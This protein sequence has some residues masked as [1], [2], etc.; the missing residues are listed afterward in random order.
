MA[1]GTVDVKRHDQAWIVSLGG[2]H[3]L[4][5]QPMLTDQLRRLART[6]D[7]GAEERHHRESGCQPRRSRPG[8]SDGC[9]SRDG[10]PVGHGEVSTGGPRWQGKHREPGLMSLCPGTCWSPRRAVR[11]RS[12]PWGHTR[13]KPGPGTR[14]TP[15][16]LCTTA[17]RM[18]G[19]QGR[20]SASSAETMPRHFGQASGRTSWIRVAAAW[21]TR[22]AGGPPLS[23]V[24]CLVGMGAGRP[25]ASCPSS[26]EARPP[27]LT[28]RCL[29][30]RS[31]MA[32][33]APDAELDVAAPWYLLVTSESG[34]SP[35]ATMGPY[36]SH[37][38]ARRAADA[39]RVMYYRIASGRSARST[40]RVTR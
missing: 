26:G 2:E 14:R 17:S 39:A 11:V 34:K 22:S 13:P 40:V 12:R 8:D 37:A 9:P 3:D 30:R 15:R 20:R 35:F 38:E 32:R 21:E 24:P 31:T 10:G 18:P 19:A 36:T 29:H 6:G 5:T 28:R 7:C 1:V 4:T 16:E 33:N 23:E 27:V 25:R